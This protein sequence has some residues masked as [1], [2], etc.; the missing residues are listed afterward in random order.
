MRFVILGG[1]PGGY[2]AAATAAD[3]GAEV[4]IIERRTLGG[5]WTVTDGIP[6]KTLIHTAAVMASIE[7]AESV[8]IQFEHGRPRV[9]L[10]GTIAYARWVAAHQARGVRERLDATEATI[11]YGDGRVV[12]DGLLEVR[13]EGGVEAVAY[14][15][16]L[17]CTGAAPWQPPFA[18]VDHE[19]IL[20]TRDVLELEAFPEHL[21]VVGAGSTGSEF[22]EFFSSCGCRTTLL[23]SRPQ[24]LPSS[25]RD[26]AEVVQEAFLRRAVEIVLD[27][28]A[29]AIEHAGQGVMVTTTDSR[30]YHG[31]HAIVCMGMRPDTSGLGLAE[32]GVALGSRGEIVVDGYGRTSN[33]SIYAAGDV[34]GG[35]ML[36]ST[37]AMQGR[38]AVLHGV[39]EDVEPVSIEGIAG[40]VF[41][42]PEV[43]EVGLSETRAHATGADV[44]VTRHP[45]RANPRALI[46]G[47]TDGMIKLIWEP[48]GGRLLGGSIVGY[49]AS[50][51]ITPVA[52]AVKCGLTV[53]DLA[54]TGAVNP[55]VSESL[56]RC[57]EKAANIRRA[58]AGTRVAM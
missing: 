35:W 15:R 55:S 8:G 3:L 13:T 24:I 17:I 12:R 46:G 7:Q 30:Q 10:M 26:I 16:L 31:S 33:E 20:N 38:L 52:L 5:N 54:T 22:A 2:A 1:G 14:D 37:A 19:R 29:A 58:R 36:A 50:E 11:L 51:V 49:R 4:T 32:A 34:T 42:R 25:D 56:Q 21:L 41:T 18:Q 9:D 53:D 43:A 47:Q 28:R 40:T 48:E 27:A 45:L 39:G 6:S 23:S 57:A 44:R